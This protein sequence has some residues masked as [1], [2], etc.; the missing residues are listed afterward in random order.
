MSLRQLRNECEI[1]ETI[2]DQGKN[3]LVIFNDDPVEGSYNSSPPLVI[4][5]SKVNR[6]VPMHMLSCVSRPN[7]RG[8]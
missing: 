1:N 6:K 4:Q 3:K 2:R 8:I 7:L 5:K